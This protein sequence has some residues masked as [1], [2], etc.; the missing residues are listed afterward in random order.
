M[1]YRT[2]FAVILSAVLVAGLMFGPADA[3]RRRRPPACKRFRGGTEG[4]GQPVTLV[5]SR[6]TK[7]KPVTRQMDVGMGFGFSSTDDN[8]GQGAPSH[9]VM[10]VQVDSRTRTSGLWILLEAGELRDLDLHVSDAAGNVVAY[11]AGFQAA[12]VGGLPLVGGTDG[13]G[14][15]GKTTMTSEQIDGLKTR[16]CTGYT[17]EV[18]G[19]G[20]EDLTASLKFWLGKAVYDPA[21]Q[22]G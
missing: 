6:A 21:A 3:R 9:Q 22:E 11:S 7:A 13:T 12:P 19:A 14:Q 8:E 20:N 16:D 1:R 17:I 4:K 15:G 2:T 18:W 5:T 10:N